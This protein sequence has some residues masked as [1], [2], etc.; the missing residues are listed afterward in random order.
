MRSVV[1]LAVFPYILNE[2]S[3]NFVD[4]FQ[5]TFIFGVAKCT[6]SHGVVKAGLGLVILLS[7]PY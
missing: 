1:E 6:A 5:V 7:Y 3:V 4:F 2:N